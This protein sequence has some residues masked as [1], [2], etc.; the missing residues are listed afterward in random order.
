MESY[1]EV[2]AKFQIPQYSAEHDTDDFPY[3][4]GEVVDDNDTS[5]QNDDPSDTT[6]KADTPK[7]GTFHNDG[8][9][10]DTV[11]INFDRKGK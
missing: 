4:E 3:V 5:A 11:N 6:N 9:F 2:A 10:I 8:L 1:P 7:Y